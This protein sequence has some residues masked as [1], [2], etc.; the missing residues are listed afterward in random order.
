MPAAHDAPDLSALPPEVRAAFEAEKTSLTAERAARLHLE[1][2]MADRKAYAGRLEALLREMR[3][4]RFGP[5]SEKLH[6]DQLA[7][8]L[9]EIETAIAE[10]KTGHENRPAA[11]AADKAAKADA[12]ERPQPQGQRRSSGS[13]TRSMRGR[14]AGRARC[15]FGAR[16]PALSL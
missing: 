1:A 6:P 5:R 12:P 13:I 9:E 14:S 10:A 4:A 16:G 3:R 2:E 8:A 7:F 15:G 11:K